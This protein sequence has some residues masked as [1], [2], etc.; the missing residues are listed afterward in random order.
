MSSFVSTTLRTGLIAAGLALGAAVSIPA[1][2]QTT[3]TAPAANSTVVARGTGFTITEKDIATAAE[4][5]ALGT[6]NLPE[7]QRREAVIDYLVNMKILGQAAEAAKIDADPDFVSKLAEARQQLLIE[8]FLD[9]ETQKAVTPEAARK[10]YDETTKEMK[11]EQEVR[12][13]HILVETEEQAKA[14]V[15]RLKKGKDFAKVAAETSK[16]PGS[17][18]TGGE[19]GF[20][21]K[22]RMVAPFAEAAFKLEPNQIS[23]PVQTQFGWH[24]IQTEEKRSQPIPSF[25]DLKPQ[26]ETF[27]GRQAQQQI[28]TSLREK[29]NVERL[30]KPA[31]DKAPA[32]APKTK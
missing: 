4:N 21:T 30:D 15:A 23:E 5:P 18:E 17:K 13:R 11:P 12:A 20:F 2:A 22:D 29:A 3:A 27:L 10:L 1:V 25:D 26:I 16:D 28:L 14:I 8:A 19:L 31:T 9:K 24:V 32:E 7:E 6:S